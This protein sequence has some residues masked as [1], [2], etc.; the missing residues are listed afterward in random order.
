MIAAAAILFVSF[1]PL[2]LNWIGQ[3]YAPNEDDGQFDGFV[4]L[5]VPNGLTDDTYTVREVSAPEGGAP[6]QDQDVNLG[7]GRFEVAAQAAAPEGAEPPTT[8]PGEEAPGPDEPVLE[9]GHRED[10][11]GTLPM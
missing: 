10:Q 7:R 9:P 6:A 2:Q 5:R 8:E 1:L 11:R 4:S 3:E